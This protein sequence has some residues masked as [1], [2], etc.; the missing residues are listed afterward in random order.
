MKT[1]SIVDTN[2]YIVW[3]TAQSALASHYASTNF[4]MLTRTQKNTITSHK[5]SVAPR[6][7]D[8][9]RFSSVRSINSSSASSLDI[10]SLPHRDMGWY[11]GMPPVVPPLSR[12]FRPAAA[13]VFGSI[14]EQLYEGC[15]N[16][17]LGEMRL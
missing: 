9:A 15:G 17:L 6:G 11:A 8:Q 10:R 16:Q 5:N 7:A 1:A 4:T 14:R 3:I 13:E 12:S 2:K